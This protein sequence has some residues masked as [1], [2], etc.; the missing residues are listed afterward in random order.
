MSDTKKI[1]PSKLERLN[2]PERLN[3]IP[4]KT[5][6]ETIQLSNPVFC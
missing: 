3:A 1:D 2:N 5:I 4:P 6:W